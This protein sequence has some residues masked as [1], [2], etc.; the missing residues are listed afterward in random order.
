MLE[1]ARTH[2]WVFTEE[3][4]KYLRE[5][6]PSGAKRRGRLGETVAA[7]RKDFI[8]ERFRQRAE[9]GEALDILEDEAQAILDQLRESH[10]EA[11]LPSIKTIIDLLHDNHLEYCLSRWHIERAQRREFRRALQLYRRVLLDLNLY[12]DPFSRDI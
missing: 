12:E 9:D 8:I 11:Q 5:I 4:K 3:A 6:F 2:N 10:P 7:I 1:E